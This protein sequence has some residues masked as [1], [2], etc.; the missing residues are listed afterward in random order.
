VSAVGSLLFPYVLL[1]LTLLR[2]RFRLVA[3][4]DKLWEALCRKQWGS[5]KERDIFRREGRVS[6]KVTFQNNHHKDRER[7]R[8]LAL[9]LSNPVVCRCCG[10]KTASIQSQQRNVQYIQWFECVA[11][12]ERWDFII[13]NG[14]GFFL[15]LPTSFLTRMVR[16]FTGTAFALTKPN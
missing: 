8:R 16:R 14:T 9:L 12:G 5:L 13:E 7:A 4:E 15:D 10:E 11:C 3:K 1:A 2:S 6:W